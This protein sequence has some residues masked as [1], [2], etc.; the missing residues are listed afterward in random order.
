M[1]FKNI[2]SQDGVIGRFRNAVGNNRLAG[3][4]I[5]TGPEG[6]G[7]LLF[8]EELARYI[9]CKNPDGDSCGTCSSC[10]KMSSGSY[11]D[12]SILA[13]LPEEK[14]IKIKYIRELQRQLYLKPLEGNKKI[15]IINDAHK[16]NEESSNCFLKS[17]EEPP[18]D[19]IIILITHNL[20]R[21]L[22]TIQ[23]RAVIV[24]FQPIDDKTIKEMLTADKNISSEDASFITAISAGSLSKAFALAGSD[25]K[26]K[27]AWLNSNILAIRKNNN[28][29]LTESLLAL[30]NTAGGTRQQ[31]REAV[32]EMLD[33][34]LLFFRWML[35]AP[36]EKGKNIV[37][38][39]SPFPATCK[40]LSQID[41]EKIIIELLDARRHIDLNA[42]INM[43]LEIMFHRIGEIE[44]SQRWQEAM[45]S[46]TAK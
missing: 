14:E 12:F 46:D 13:V 42:N 17:F 20:S 24:H 27:R 36:R 31:L 28:F 18:Q 16:L 33:M 45:L 1:S 21:I 37:L 3:A 30:C 32:L 43:A 2:K 34:M 44:E 6:V 15:F 22:P 35:M 40:F 29:D 9:F 23:S 26:D 38:E 39:E 7:K 5:F 25:F 19:S 41:L 10:R 4:Y 8:A 11:P